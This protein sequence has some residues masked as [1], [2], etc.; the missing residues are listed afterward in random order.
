MDD[1]KIDRPFDKELFKKASDLA[2]KY[3]ILMEKHN[4][5]GYVGS[6][7]EMPTVFFDGKTEEQCEKSGR[8]A[9]AVT[10]ATMMELGRELP[11][12]KYNE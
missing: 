7:V 8:E 1:R 3:L 5:L 11:K 10:I 9:I 6:C 12:V 2:Q 4:R